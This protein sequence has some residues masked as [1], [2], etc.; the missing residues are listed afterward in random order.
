MVRATGIGATPLREGIS[1]L[2]A[3]GLVVAID[4]R[5]FRVS[6]LSRQDLDDIITTRLALES[7]ALRL[8]IRNGDDQWE[9]EIV[10]SLHRLTKFL[11]NIPTTPREALKGFDEVH[12]AFHISLISACGSPRMLHFLEILYDQALRYRS[13]MVLKQSIPL[14]YPSGQTLADNH[15]AL[16][17]YAI[18]RDED[19]IVEELRNHLHT[20]ALL[21][22]S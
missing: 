14:S 6:K 10:G 17:K 13:M 19:A 1:R 9:A 5:G 18:E 3:R 21:V 4:R 22:F 7:E 2:I 11:A 20:F 8:S 15:S 16:A 12:K